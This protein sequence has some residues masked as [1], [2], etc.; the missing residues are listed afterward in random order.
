MCNS[1]EARA[2]FTQLVDAMAQARLPL[3]WPERGSAPN[4]EPLD[5]V[6]PTDMTPAIRMRSEGG[7]T[8]PEL[9]SLRFGLP[10]ARPKAPPVINFRSE[11]RRFGPDS[12][13]ARCLVPVTSFFEYTGTKYPKTRWRVTKPD[14]PDLFALAALC[15][16]P[17]AA[18]EKP[19]P[20]SFTLLTTEPGPDIAP[21]H[22]RQMVVLHRADWARWLDPEADPADLLKPLPAGALKVEQG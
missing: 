12:K 18:A 2:N 14:E 10:P 1:F 4:L 11:G 15:R 13:L 22:D 17:D 9:T 16:G 6:R 7:E 5:L 21:V 19:W 3:R 8:G 20:A